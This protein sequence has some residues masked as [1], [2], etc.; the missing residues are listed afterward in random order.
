[1]NDIGK[2]IQVTPQYGG[3]NQLEELLILNESGGVYWCL[4]LNEYKEMQ[5]DE[6]TFAPWGSGV[7]AVT[8]K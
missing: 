6:V 8:N 2:I 1:M 5:C 7:K 3:D 4:S